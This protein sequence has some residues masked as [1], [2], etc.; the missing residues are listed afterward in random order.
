VGVREVVTRL[1]EILDERRYEAYSASSGV[2]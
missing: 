1:R 2:T